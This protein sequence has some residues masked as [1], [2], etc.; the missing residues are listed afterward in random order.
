[1]KKEMHLFPRGY[2]KYFDLQLLICEVLD[3]NIVSEVGCPTWCFH[4]VLQSLHTNAG[5]APK[6]TP[7]LYLDLSKLVIHSHSA[8]QP[9]I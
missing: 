3:S 8:S 6:S 1:M 4:R 7:W 9:Y 5:M 2:K